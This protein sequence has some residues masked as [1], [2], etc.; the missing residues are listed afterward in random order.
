[1]ENVKT[2][3]RNLLL[4][5]IYGLLLI[6]NLLIAAA[7]LKAQGNDKKF[8]TSGGLGIGVGFFAPKGVNDYI[9]ADLSNYITT[10]ES[11]FMYEEVNAFL[12]FKFRYFD[13]TGIAEFALGPKF[14]VGA[15]NNTSYFFNR[16]S[17]GVLANVFLPTGSS[18]KYALFLGG[19]IQYHMMTFEG[20]SGQTLGFR[21]QLGYDLQ[22]GRVDIQPTLAVNLIPKVRDKIEID[23]TTYDMNYTG[24]Q[25]GVNVSFHKPVLHR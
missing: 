15:G 9:K 19:G 16:F 10:N 8:A 22:V 14:V 2:I 20:F 17:P 4:Y 13:I 25:I 23:N 21:G 12:N 7:P 5:R 24:V 18:G 3:L 11:L 1:M 6:I